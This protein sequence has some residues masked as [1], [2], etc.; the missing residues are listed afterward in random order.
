M[1]LYNMVHWKSPI[2]FVILSMIWLNENN[3][4]R[5]R[6][7]F[8]DLE[9]NEI[10]VLTRM[11]WWN[12]TYFEKEIKELQSNEFYISDDDADFDSTYAW[13][14]FKIP[15]EF[16]VDL[17]LIWDKNLFW[18]SKKLLDK[19]LYCYKDNIDFIEWLKTLP[20]KNI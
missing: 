5:Y 14:N 6:D 19:I 4:W 10:L 1:S 9:K 13:F 3:I 18:I 17:S 12:R 8:I 15:E 2:W 16:K 7:V 11:W 20:F